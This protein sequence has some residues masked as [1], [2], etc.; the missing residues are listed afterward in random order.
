MIKI[1]ACFILIITLSSYKLSTEVSQEVKF[2]MF[3]CALT[4]TYSTSKDYVVVKVKNLKTGEMKEICVTSNLLMGAL[5]LEAGENPIQDYK[6]NTKLY[7]EFLKDSALST[8]GFN[9]YA[10]QELKSFQMH[11]NIDSFVDQIKLGKIQSLEYDNNK[12]YF[13]HTLFNHGVVTTHGCY[14]TTVHFFNEA[15]R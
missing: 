12:K 11:L 6:K 3:C 9:E 13:A 5:R 8:I 7:F 4:K 2:K 1:V 10:V 14:G 15:C